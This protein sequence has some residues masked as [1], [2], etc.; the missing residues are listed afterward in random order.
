[1]ITTK[2]AAR[3]HS[4]GYVAAPQ[5]SPAVGASQLFGD[6]AMVV[7]P[8]SSSSGGIKRLASS[9]EEL[10]MSW[11][12]LGTAPPA[13]RQGLRHCISSDGA[14]SSDA[15]S[16]DDW[17]YCDRSSKRQ[18]RANYASASDDDAN[19]M[20]TEGSSGGSDGAFFVTGV[21]IACTN[22]PDRNSQVK[23]GWY[24]GQLDAL[25]NRSGRGITKHDDGTEYDGTYANDL[26]DGPGTYKFVTYNSFVTN[27]H[28]AG[29]NLH[30]LTEKSFVGTFEKDEP[31]GAGMI[32]TRTV[33]T[34]PQVLGSTPPDIKYVEVVY[35][36]GMYRKD[37]VG[38][39]VRIIYA[40]TNHG[41]RSTLEKTCYRLISGENTNVKVA[42]DYAAWIVQCMGLEF[43]Y[44]ASF[45]G[46]NPIPM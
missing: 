2:G 10:E 26:M 39:G 9:R 29:S 15:P 43:P 28:S 6:A 8:A 30:R 34:A 45:G 44:P 5:A 32:I 1:M 31:R 27:P 7:A 33:D 40:T 23:A 13:T 46:L 37:A 25:G 24:E 16:E 11:Q 22:R 12:G 21:R 20:G 4:D 38:E 42:P 35:D 18:R 3:F 41:G 36:V 19:M 14:Y 17:G